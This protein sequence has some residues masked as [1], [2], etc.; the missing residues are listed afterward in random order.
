M[1]DPYPDRI[2]LFNGVR[3]SGS[4]KAKKTHKKR[5]SEC[6]LCLNA[7]YSIWKAVGNMSQCLVRK[8]YSFQQQI[9]K[10]LVINGFGSGSGFTEESGSGFNEYGSATLLERVFSVSVVLS[11]NICLWKL[12]IHVV[13][14]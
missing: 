2:Q 10:C 3:G 5:K 7:A 1:L 13:R 8:G 4:R 6:I 11:G 14:N 12:P 9:C